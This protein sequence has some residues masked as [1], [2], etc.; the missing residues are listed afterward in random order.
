M[1]TVLLAVLLL[2]VA[3][4]LAQQGPPS[5]ESLRQLFAAS[6]VNKFL[7]AYMAQLDSGIQAGMR[8]ALNGKTP[9]ARQQQILDDMRAR[10]VEL[11]RESLTW[12]KLEP[13]MTEIYRKDF[14]QREVDDMLKFYRSPTGVAMIDKMPLVMQQASQSVQGM[15]PPLIEKLQQVQKEGAARLKAADNAADAGA[16]SS[17]PA[18]PPPPH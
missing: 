9:N 10:I 11:F 17:A 7:D 18:P 14:T 6:H 2:Q 3:P 8:S 4:A 1:R 5:A 15:L 16:P 12:E 13:T